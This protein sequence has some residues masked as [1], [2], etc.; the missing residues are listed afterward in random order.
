[1]QI[2]FLS[3]KKRTYSI[4]KI[5]SFNS[6]GIQIQKLNE[7]IYRIDQQLSKETKELLKAQTIVFK[8]AFSNKSYW[9]NRFLTKVYWS[10][11]K[12]TAEWYRNQIFLLFKEKRKLEIQLD[13]LT[14]KYWIKQ[15]RKW[16]LIILSGTITIFIVWI[17]LLGILT[18]LY[19]MPIWGSI[20][21]LYFFF[22]KRSYKL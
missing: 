9:H 12:E 21:L 5:S 6:K 2:W 19:L 14:G 10:K 18:S 11:A 20:L 15:L 3:P 16:L 7:E 1:M 8:A 13:L 17:I 22:Q 4:K